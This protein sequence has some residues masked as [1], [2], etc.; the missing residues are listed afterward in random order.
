MRCEKRLSLT[1]IDMTH[2]DEETCLLEMHVRIDVDNRIASQLYVV[3][4]I[5]LYCILTYGGTI[6]WRIIFSEVSDVRA[7][8]HL[9][10]PRYFKAQI[11]VAVYIDVRNRKNLCLTRFLISYLIFPVKRS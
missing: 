9:Q 10:H 4:S 8:I 11:Q 1:G 3:F 7:Q 2:H 6:V 5:V